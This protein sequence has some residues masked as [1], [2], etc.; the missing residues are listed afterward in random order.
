M[1]E[2]DPASEDNAKSTVAGYVLT[3]LSVAVIIGVAIPIGQWRDP[4]THRP[5]PRIVAVALP[6]LLAAS[7]HGIGTVLL[8]LMGLRIWSK[9]ETEESRPPD[10]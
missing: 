2:H 4:A 9:P 10:G 5:L 7:F 3:L 1:A 8:R 6:F